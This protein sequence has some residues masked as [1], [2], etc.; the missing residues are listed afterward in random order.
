MRILV[1]SVLLMASC[2]KQPVH[3]PVGAVLD[4]KDLAVSRDRAKALN[5]LERR[6]IEEWMAGQDKKFYPMGLNYWTDIKGLNERERKSDGAA[7]SYAYTVSD[8]EGNSLIDAPVNKYNVQFGKFE[9]LK[10]VE[11]ALRYMNSGESATLLVPSVLGFGTYGDN[12][13]IS[14]D[15]PLIITLKSL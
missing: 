14:N 15:M 2:A 4:Q 9:E 1:F 5:T 8:F 11:D 3:P 10:S 12:K 13:K 7:V 6:Q